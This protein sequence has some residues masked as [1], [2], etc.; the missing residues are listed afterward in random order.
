MPYEEEG[1]MLLTRETAKVIAAWAP[2]VEVEEIDPGTGERL[3]ALNVQC[4]DDVKR[5]SVDDWVIKKED[6]TFDVKKPNEFL[7]YLVD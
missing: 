1:A 3:P 4:G 2:S 6:G 5:A 7:Q